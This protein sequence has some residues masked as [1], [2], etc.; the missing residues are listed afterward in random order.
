MPE[1]DLEKMI[2]ELKQ[3]LNTLPTDV[4]PLLLVI[5]SLDQFIGEKVLSWLPAK[6]H[7]YANLGV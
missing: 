6:L 5:D 7:K 3:C 4:Q 2:V 1:N